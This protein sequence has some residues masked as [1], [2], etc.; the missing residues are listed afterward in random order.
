MARL[1]SPQNGFCNN[2]ETHHF[3]NFS[4]RNFPQNLSKAHPATYQNFPELLPE[5]NHQE[6]DINSGS[7]GTTTYNQGHH[8]QAHQV[9]FNWLD[10]LN[11]ANSHKGLERHRLHSI[12]DTPSK[13]KVCTELHL[14]FFH[15]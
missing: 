8:Q 5:L 4:T 15:Q 10:I 2:S 11:E 9:E 1:Y 6:N 3:L 12:Y 14:F 7:G 13:F